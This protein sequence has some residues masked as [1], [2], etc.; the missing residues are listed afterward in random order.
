MTVTWARLGRGDVDHERLWTL[1]GLACFAVGLFAVKVAGLPPIGCAFKA[2]TGLPCP[3]CGG[4]RAMA[5]LADGRLAHAV[6]MNP[7]V[8]AAVLGWA[9]YI[10]YGLWFGWSGRD[11]PRVSLSRADWATARVVA[12]AAVAATWLFLIL[13][14]R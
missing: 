2:L 11:R 1:V 9:A 4:T 3:T 13:D 12:V 8:T 10:P 5:A 7:L 14:G 6:R